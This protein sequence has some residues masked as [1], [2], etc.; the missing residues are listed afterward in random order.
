MARSDSGSLFEHAWITWRGRFV[1]LT[2]QRTEPVSGYAVS[3]D[4]VRTTIL[5]RAAWGAIHPVW[6]DRLLREVDDGGRAD[7]VPP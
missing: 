5:E 7:V 6:L 4:V 1:D 3:A 2:L